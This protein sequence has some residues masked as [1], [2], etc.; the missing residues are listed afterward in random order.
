MGYMDVGISAATIAKTHGFN[1]SYIRAEIKAGRLKAEKIGRDW[2][3][4][5]DEY[6]RWMN[7]PKRKSRSSK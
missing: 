2:F 5:K 7:N 4:D 6:H 3:I 1:P